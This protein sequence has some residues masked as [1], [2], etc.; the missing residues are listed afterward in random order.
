ML[1]YNITLLK[2]SHVSGLAPENYKDRNHHWF[3]G[4]LFGPEDGCDTLL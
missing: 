3:L 1:K 2:N 4:L